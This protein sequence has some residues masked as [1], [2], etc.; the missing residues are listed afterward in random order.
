MDWHSVGN[1]LHCR[2]ERRRVCHLQLR[3][4]NQGQGKGFEGHALSL[5][6]LDGCM[7]FQSA[8]WKD[9]SI[10]LYAVSPEGP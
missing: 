7:A 6:I 3:L 1:V 10:T 9:I 8:S 5:V 4:Y 2:E